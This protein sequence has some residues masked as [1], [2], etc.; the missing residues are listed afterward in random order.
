MD[1]DRPMTITA[2]LV[3]PVPSELKAWADATQDLSVANRLLE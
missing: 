3:P 1:G 2:Q